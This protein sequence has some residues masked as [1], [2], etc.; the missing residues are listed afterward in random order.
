MTTYTCKCGKT[1][2][3]NTGAGTTGLRMPDYGP[4]H[5]CFGCPFVCQ[6]M[7]WDPT[8]QKEA[9][10][11]HECRAS[12]GIRYDSTAALSLGDKCV[13]RIDSLD[14]DF[15]HRV[16][17][18]ADGLDGI[19]PD[20]NAFSSRGAD[21]GTDGRYRLTI[22]PAA[23]N[24]GV[25]AKQQLFNEFF[26]PDGTRKNFCPEE[27]KEIVLRQIQDGKREAQHIMTQ[28]QHTNKVYFVKESDDG[29]F[30]A[31][32]YYKANPPKHIPVGDIPPCDAEWIAQ[33][34]LDDYAQQRE[35][36]VYDPDFTGD[37]NPE[38]EQQRFGEEPEET[39]DSVP[40]SDDVP[41][42]VQ[43]DEPL[44]SVNDA[45]SESEDSD[46]SENDGAEPTPEGCSW[47]NASGSEDE[48]QEDLEEP[49][50]D[51]PELSLRLSAFNAVFNAADEA[52]QDMAR[53]LKT[54]FIESGELNLKIVIDN[55]GGVL[56]PNLKKS[57]GDCSLKPAKVSFPIRFSADVEFIVGN[58][59][60]VILP[61]D[62]E[63]QISFDEVP[64]VVTQV[65][66]ST[67]L[68]ESVAVQED[69]QPEPELDKDGEGEQ[70]EDESDNE[71][72][73]PLYPCSCSDCLFFAIG[74]DEDSGCCFD[75]Q[76]SESNNYPGDVW[77]AVHMNGCVRPEVLHAYRKNNPE[78]ESYDDTP[79]DSDDL[80]FESP[81]N[82][83]EEAS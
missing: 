34:M 57:K 41:D 30:R 4:E 79:D 48:P 3:K 42:M 50:P 37:E 74:V 39:D 45:H 54:K 58:D 83:E 47:Q 20:R 76:D 29:K 17:E 81:E 32:F 26:N 53:T 69:E 18:Y 73:E 66:G 71:S 15:L 10:Q 23:N 13:G 12:K 60:R 35:F 27:E 61:E 82:D 62:R 46:E 16:R 59:G 28:Y 44:E 38:M 80:P 1:F 63:H 72:S 67:G 21:Y 40:D 55:Y 75:S 8:T 24:K 11:N 78:N 33:K 52:L 36:E 56:R 9:V 7:T 51:G 43:E 14:F 70:T 77:E 6:V 25:A 31:Y 68:V 5:E 49:L 22:Y 65:D 19:E 64:P 2:D